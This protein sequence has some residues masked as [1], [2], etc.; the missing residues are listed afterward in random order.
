[1]LLPT[2]LSSL[3]LQEMIIIVH[4]PP[5]KINNNNIKN[6]VN[7]Y[8]WN[9][10]FDRQLQRIEYIYECKYLYEKKLRIKHFG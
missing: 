8:H 7:N 2:K 10:I 6:V 9:C 5:Y 3:P 1:M 4:H